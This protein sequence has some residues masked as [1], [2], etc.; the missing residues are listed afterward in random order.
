M[1]NGIDPG[2]T[3]SKSKK[4]S[5][6]VKNSSASARVADC[7]LWLHELHLRLNLLEDSN[8]KLVAELA[9]KDKVIKNLEEVDKLIKGNSSVASAQSRS[10]STFL[11][12]GT[13][14][15]KTTE[16]DMVLM[17][18][19]RAESK[20]ITEKENNIIITG[21]KESESEDADDKMNDDHE[22]AA[23]ILAALGNTVTG[24]IKKIY[25]RGRNSIRPR[26]LV[27]ELANKDERNTAI[28]NAK[29]LV[30]SHET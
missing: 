16:L 4:Y 18:K 2:D 20:E 27:V 19:I 8:K 13:V 6:A 12:K 21:L 7:D 9:E 1:S 10:W 26:P 22:T 14:Q 28:R 29:L 5:E 11:Q 17:A 30:F 15:H 25:R 23:A 3:V 24:T